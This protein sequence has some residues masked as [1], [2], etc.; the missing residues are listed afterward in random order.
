MLRMN[1]I[2]MCLICAMVTYAQFK[3][4]TAFP[5]NHIAPQNL[6]FKNT[7]VALKSAET[8]KLKALIVPLDANTTSNIEI[9]SSTNIEGQSV[10]T[11]NQSLASQLIK[12]ILMDN[13]DSLNLHQVQ[14]I[15]QLL[16]SSAQ[17]KRKEFIFY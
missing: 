17:V 12:Q 5:K 15:N 2:F 14:A 9:N 4:I 6:N 1:L 16:K 7:K 13:A 10:E 8:P 3:P 11:P